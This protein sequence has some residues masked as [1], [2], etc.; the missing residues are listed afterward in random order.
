MTEEE[1]REVRH[2]KE[3]VELFEKAVDMIKELNSKCQK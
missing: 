3:D 1:Q 2:L